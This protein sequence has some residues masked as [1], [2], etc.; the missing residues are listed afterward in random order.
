MSPSRADVHEHEEQ[1]AA[2]TRCRVVSARRYGAFA[3]LELL[4]PEV[5]AVA[6]PGQFVMVKVPGG[7]FLLRRPLSLFTARADRVGL[8][9]ESRGP[10]SDRL[11]AV[12]VGDTLDIAGPLGTGFPVRLYGEN[13]IEAFWF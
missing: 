6:W 2:T 5:A 13:L 11:A 7:G 12:A 10:G 1:W 3:A 8:L 4:A 9:I